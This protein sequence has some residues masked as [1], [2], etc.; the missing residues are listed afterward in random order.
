MVSIDN[1]LRT[2]IYILKNT[3]FF[4]KRKKI[5][6]SLKPKIIPNRIKK[7]KALKNKIKLD[8][9]DYIRMNIFFIIILINIIKGY[10]SLFL[11][12]DSYIKF[13]TNTNNDIKLFHFYLFDKKYHC[14]KLTFPDIIEYD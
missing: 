10:K 13:K 6:F 2:I 11:S 5:E 8:K 3:F 7:I 4:P 12:N 14:E 9:L 1:A